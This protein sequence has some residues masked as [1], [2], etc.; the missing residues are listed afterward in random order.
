MVSIVIVEKTGVLKCVTMKTYDE[1]ELY[2][3]AG[4]K[5]E[6][7]FV[8]HTTWKLGSNVNIQLFGKTTG[9][10]GQENKYDFPPPVDSKLFFGSCI[11]VNTSDVGDVLDLSIKQWEV[12]YEKLFGGFEDIGNEDSDDEDDE[13]EDEDAPRTKEGYVKDDFIVDDDEDDEEE[14]EEE[15]EED[16]DADDDDDEDDAPKRKKKPV[17]KRSVKNKR[18]N[19]VC[20]NVFTSIESTAD[21]EYLDCTSELVEEDYV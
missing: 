4:L 16:E 20:A 11:L 7:G 1:S 18:K 6:S 19:A 15:E 8:R 21:G 5:T 14:E 12:V 9:R 10:A 17:A 3:K 2:K 13:D